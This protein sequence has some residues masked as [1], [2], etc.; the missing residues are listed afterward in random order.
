MKRLTRLFVTLF[1]L[2]MC[3]S[4]FAGASIRAS[5]QLDEY[6]TFISTGTSGKITIKCTAKG[7]GI[8]DE[9]GVS[10][11]V[12]YEKNGSSMTSVET[13]QGTSETD[14]V[15]YSDTFYFDGD[16]G[17]T[18]QIRVTFFAENS[19]GYDTGITSETVTA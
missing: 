3:L 4:I 16:S 18:Y 11:I 1:V 2:A 17:T 6:K 15:S 7:T 10:R 13:I 9:I 5:G 14:T 19:E 12:I 8:M